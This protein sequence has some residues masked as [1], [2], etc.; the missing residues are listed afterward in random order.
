MLVDDTI[1]LQ[2]SSL[3]SFKLDMKVSNTID[4]KGYD[5]TKRHLY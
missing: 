4:S 2:E 3:H 1:P 5:K